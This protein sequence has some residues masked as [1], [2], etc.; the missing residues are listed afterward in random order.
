MCLDH[1]SKQ[2]QLVG[3]VS[4]GIK[5]QVDT[6]GIAWRVSTFLPFIES[7]IHDGK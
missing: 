7:L 3:I 2:W 5:C 4:H 1:T 6:P